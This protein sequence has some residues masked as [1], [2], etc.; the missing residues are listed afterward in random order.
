M[1]ETS[2]TVRCEQCGELIDELPRPQ[3][4]A[5]FATIRDHIERERDRQGITEAQ[6]RIQPFQEGSS[7]G[8]WYAEIRLLE[9]Q[10]LWTAEPWGSWQTLR[11]NPGARHALHE[12]I[13]ANQ[14]RLPVAR[15][16]KHRKAGT[17]ARASRHNHR[18]LP[19]PKVAEREGQPTRRPLAGATVSAP[20]TEEGTMDAKEITRR[21][22]EIYDRKLKRH[23][24]RT[25]GGKYVAINLNTEEY[26][27]GS[28][29]REAYEAFRAR[30]PAPTPGHIIEI[31]F[32]A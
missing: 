23:L 22:R 4:Q 9:T 14:L 24:E 27:I 13:I 10:L 6:L 28:T 7:S 20:P 12:W 25:D 5:E 11:C 16:P 19:S 29:D 3:A 1:A 18:R 2:V 26:V 17:T 31:P 21:G 15:S 30:F 32:A 8:S